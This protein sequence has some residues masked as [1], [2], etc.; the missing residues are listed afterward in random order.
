MAILNAALR[1]SELG[2][3]IDLS[4]KVFGSLVAATLWQPLATAINTLCHVA[5]QLM[6]LPARVLD[7]LAADSLALIAQME[8]RTS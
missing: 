3:P 4:A 1:L 2:S 5:A 6:S 8:A 7:N